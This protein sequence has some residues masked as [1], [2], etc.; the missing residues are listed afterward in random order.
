MNISDTILNI[1]STHLDFIE[2]ESN[3]DNY[4]VDK[5][6]DPTNIINSASIIFVDS[7]VYRLYKH[8]FLNVSLSKII[9]IEAL[10]SNKTVE[11]SL[12]LFKILINMGI[13]KSDSVVVIGG[14]IVQDICSFTCQIYKRG[15]N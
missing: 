10:E 8:L 13:K 9:Q 12:N 6:K 11:T 5:S 7:N 15:I 1:E 2:I 3:I 4:F 14:G